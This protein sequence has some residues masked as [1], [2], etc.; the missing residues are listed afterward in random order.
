MKK[1]AFIA[2]SALALLLSIAVGAYM[3]KM[4][5]K[6][7]LEHGTALDPPKPLDGIV[8]IDSKG[9]LVDKEDFKGHWTLLFLGYAHCPDVCPQSLG[10]L[11]GELDQLEAK[12]VKVEVA[13]ASV[14]SER[15]DPKGLSAFLAAVDSRFKGYI[16]SETM[17]P[18]L[19][20]LFGVYLNKNA[21]GTFSHSNAIFVLDPAA[22]WVA[23]YSQLPMKGFLASDIKRIAMR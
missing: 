14:D 9:L 20:E 18:K 6:L 4:H 5:A 8:L 16:A 2:V 11:K 13:F 17:V 1:S 19:T 12:G 15:D 23:V 7:P 21:D 22:Q 3:S 10:Y